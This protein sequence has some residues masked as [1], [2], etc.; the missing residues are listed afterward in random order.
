MSA[1]KRDKHRVV[2]FPAVVV[3]PPGHGKG[4]CVCT[5][6]DAARAQQGMH[7]GSGT[8][9]IYLLRKKRGVVPPLCFP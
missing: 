2:S 8:A 3:L 6:G 5:G 7:V 9:S 4:T 1:L